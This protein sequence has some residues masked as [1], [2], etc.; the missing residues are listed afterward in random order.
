M[1]DGR[2]VCVSVCLRVGGRDDAGA[3]LGGRNEGRFDMNRKLQQRAACWAI[4]LPLGRLGRG[5]EG[6]GGSVYC[7]CV[8]G[9]GV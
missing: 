8:C 9:G 2:G 5:G 6:G 4:R 3:V 7:M 1:E